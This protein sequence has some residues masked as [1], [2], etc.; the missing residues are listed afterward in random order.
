MVRIAFCLLLF[1]NTPAYSQKYTIEK[2]DVVFFSDAAIEDITAVNTK[3]A[4]LFNAGNSDIAFSIPISEFQ[5]EKSLM[6]EHFNERYMDT[7]K[8]PKS[9]FQGKI[10]GY[11]SLKAG[12]QNVKASGK[13][14]IHG[15]TR[16]ID[17]PGTIEKQGAKLNMKSKFVVRLMDH[18]I[19]I[20]QLMW[21]NIA[22]EVEVSVD[23][24]FKP[25]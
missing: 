25:Q 11:D 3:S 4:G 7:E 16:T 6:Q 23:F 10:S 18:K 20:P 8:Y 17:V 5:F 15:V 9:T 13:L 12:V 19:K 2:S 22:E 24:I 21:Q 14:S 1:F